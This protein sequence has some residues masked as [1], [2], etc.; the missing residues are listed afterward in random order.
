MMGPSD[1]NRIPRWMPERGS[2]GLRR[3]ARTELGEE[4]IRT[5]ESTLTSSWL[6][7]IRG[8]FTT[9]G[10]ARAAVANPARVDGAA[11]HFDRE[12]H[13]ETDQVSGQASAFPSLAIAFAATP[14]DVE[15][16]ELCAPDL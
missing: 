3:Y 6:S 16:D 10:T 1:L 9:R 11:V 2:E 4:R 7:A 15:C 14:K 5:V 8:W 13:A 12:P